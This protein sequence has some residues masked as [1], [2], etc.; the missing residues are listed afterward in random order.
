MSYNRERK[1]PEKVTYGEM[2]RMTPDEF[3]ARY[4]TANP[5]DKLR[6]T[7]YLRDRGKIG[8]PETP[9]Q[10]RAK[11]INRARGS[12]GFALLGLRGLGNHML[13]YTCSS[14]ILPIGELAAISEA[15][16]LLQEVE[17]KLAE[18]N[19]RLA[20]IQL[21]AIQRRKEAKAHKKSKS[22]K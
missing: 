1:Y 19:L 22:H 8:V 7:L 9:S 10:Y 13:R 17:A 20:R 4:K 6:M 21:T 15:G 5:G 11:S 3:E 16:R 12:I 18:A 14:K 2:R